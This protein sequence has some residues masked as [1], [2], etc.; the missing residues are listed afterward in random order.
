MN[1]NILFICSAN[2]DRSA[3]ADQYFSEKHPSLNFDSAGTNE[4]ICFQLGTNFISQELVEWAD[5]IFV[6]EQKHEQFVR[7]Q[8]RLQQTT[9]L[10]VLGIQDIYSFMDSALIQV[11]ENKLNAFFETLK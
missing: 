8:F 4:K 5:C 3:T 10:R 11:L 2:K 9:S 1:R 6:M 7:N